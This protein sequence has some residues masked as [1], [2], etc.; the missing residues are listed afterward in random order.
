[1]L[2]ALAC[3]WDMDSVYSLS[4][5][6]KCKAPG[7]N[8][9][10]AHTGKSL[11]VNPKGIGKIMEWKVGSNVFCLAAEEIGNLTGLSLYI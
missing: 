3:L 6:G 4:V 1:M 7:Q 5:N 9:D 10:Q 11:N 8:V 2:G